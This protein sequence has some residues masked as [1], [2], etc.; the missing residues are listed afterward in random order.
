MLYSSSGSRQKGTS[1]LPFWQHHSQDPHRR[2]LIH[3]ASVC[4]FSTKPLFAF[5]LKKKR[6][7]LV[8]PEFRTISDQNFNLMMFYLC[9][10]YNNIIL[11]G[12]V[13]MPSD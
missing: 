1:E 5:T 8:Y 13:H 7:L 12:V 3:P 9:S 6:L 4:T 10:L 11:N 2:A